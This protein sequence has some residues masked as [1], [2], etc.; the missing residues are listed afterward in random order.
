M[1][2]SLEELIGFL[3]SI[4]S[5]LVLDYRAK[6]RQLSLVFKEIEDI[7]DFSY[8]IYQL[9]SDLN[10]IKMACERGIAQNKIK[11][12]LEALHKPAS[13]TDNMAFSEYEDNGGV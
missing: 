8:C 6:Q 13:R 12:A 3:E 5:N 11:E 7:A 4:F 1:D 9:N 10:I 2:M